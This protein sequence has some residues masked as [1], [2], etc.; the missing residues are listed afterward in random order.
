[1]VLSS[2]LTPG[3][4]CSPAGRCPG[5]ITSTSALVSEFRSAEDAT[6]WA[7]VG[8]PTL[9]SYVQPVLNDKKAM[10]TV[11]HLFNGFSVDNGCVPST[12]GDA[13]V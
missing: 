4:D 5:L 12:G 2:V 7:G 11:T 13:G 1:M 3:C 8:S 10:D 9:T 6:I